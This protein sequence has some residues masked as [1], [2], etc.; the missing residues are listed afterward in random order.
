MCG[1][2]AYNRSVYAPPS[3]YSVSSPCK[4]LL[5]P[6]SPVAM[7]SFM[8]NIYGIYAERKVFP[9]SFSFHNRM[10]VYDALGRKLQD[11]EILFKKRTPKRK[12][13]KDEQ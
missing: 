12:T 6:C 11:A 4:D 10:A 8:T 1:G 13:V 7:S 5:L 9:Q 3:Q 2:T